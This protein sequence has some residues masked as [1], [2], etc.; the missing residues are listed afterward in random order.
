MVTH[1][2]QCYVFVVYR[3][4]A[5]NNLAMGPLP[6]NVQRIFP[7]KSDTHIL[8]LIPITKKQTREY[9]DTKINI[10][11]KFKNPYSLL[12]NKYK[13]HIVSHNRSK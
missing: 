4:K 9:R 12:L 10:N 6:T 2:K 7:A 3:T 5:C 11:L 8:T 13:T 1:P